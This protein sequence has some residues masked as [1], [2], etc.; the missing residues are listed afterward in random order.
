[1]FSYSSRFSPNFLRS[2]SVNWA[3]Y[4]INSMG[5]ELLCIQFALLK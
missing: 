3:D 1:M 2:N 5:F 4:F